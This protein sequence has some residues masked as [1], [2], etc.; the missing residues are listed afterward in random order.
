MAAKY[1]K[2][3]DFVI[4]VQYYYITTVMSDTQIIPDFADKNSILTY[5]I[6]LEESPCSLEQ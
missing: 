4:F 3:I 6:S 5:S 1:I 2:T